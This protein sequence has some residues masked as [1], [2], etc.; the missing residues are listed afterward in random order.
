M[1]DGLLSSWWADIQQRCSAEATYT[2]AEMNS[3]NWQHQLFQTSRRMLGSICCVPQIF[4]ISYLVSQTSL[5][6]PGAAC[7]HR[8]VPTLNS[9]VLS[10]LLHTYWCNTWTARAPAGI[11]ISIFSNR[12]AENVPFFWPFLPWLVLSFAESLLN[13][14]FFSS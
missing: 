2:A 13:P 3:T 7:T 4:L 11:I 6:S 14:L 9:S 1:E 8:A 12:G 10:H 5:T